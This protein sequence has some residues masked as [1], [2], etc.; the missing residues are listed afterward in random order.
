MLK[1]SENHGSKLVGLLIEFIL[2]F[3]MMSPW[4]FSHS[5]FLKSLKTIPG[6]FIIPGIIRCGTFCFIFIDK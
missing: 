2:D 1:L 6:L 4:R 5:S 3:S